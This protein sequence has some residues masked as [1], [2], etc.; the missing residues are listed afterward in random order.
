M[1]IMFCDLVGSTA[2]SARLDPEDLRAVIAAYYREVAAVVRRFG[3]LVARHNGDGALIYF[4]YPA[5]HEDD[6]QRAVRAGLALIVAIRGLK[7]CSDIALD[8]RIGIATGLVVIEMAGE[9]DGRRWTA[10]GETPNLAARL[11]TLAEPGT[12]VIASSTY[13]LT[14]ILFECRSL[15]LQDIKGF[16]LPV[17]V[18]QVLRLGDV[19]SRLMAQQGAR[20]PVVGRIEEIEQLMR[21]WEQAKAGEGRVV[22]ISG[23]A[24]IGKSR[25]ARALEERIGNEPHHRLYYF[26][27]ALYQDSAFFPIIGQLEH[28]AGIRREDSGETRLDKLEALLQPH[29]TD[30]R[31]EVALFAELLAIDGGDRYPPLRLSP[32]I[33]M[34]R[35]LTAL[36]SQLASL[37]A[38][39]PMLMIFEDAHWIDPSSH[40]AFAQAIEQLPT[41]PVLLILTARPEFQP[42]WVGLPHVTLQPL[43]RLNRRERIL[44]I[45]QLTNGKPLPAE[46]ME[47]IVE[48]ADGVP[49]FVEELT[50]TVVESGLLREG[51]D[52][53]VLYGP[54]PP[55]AIPTT[56]QASL[57]A[58][59]DRLGAP[60]EI[61]QEAAAIGR[62]FPYELLAA[63][64]GRNET[65][66]AMGLDQLVASGLMQQ[67]G[68]IPAASFS[69]K[70]ALMQ[71]AAYSTLVRTRRQALHGRI[72]EQ[73]EQHFSD[74][75]ETR[76]ELLAHHLAQAGFA[77]RSIGFWLK[78]ARVAIGRGATAE[79]VAQLH[80]GLALLDEVADYDNRRRQELELQIALGNA[81][82]A[83]TGY[84]GTETD[85]AFR[86]ARELCLEMGDTVQLT[87]VT[88]GQFTGHFAGGRQR[89]ALDVANE[90]LALSERFNDPGGRQIGNA[91]VG[92][93]LLHLAS[94]TAA[95]TKFE[96]ALAADSTLEREWTYLYGQSGR[97]AALAYMSLAQL[98]LG[99]PDAARRLTERSVEEARRLA[100]PTSQCFAHS[101]AS[102]VHYLLRDSKALAYHSSRVMQFAELHGLGLWQALG[103]IYVG[104]SRAET[105]PVEGAALI[106]D[107]LARY[108]VTGAAL[109][110]PLYLSSL[111]S[112]EAAGGHYLVALHLLD[113]ARA[114]SANGDEQWVS[115]EI[116]RLTGEAML[117]RNGDTAGAE[118]EF[119]AALVL[120]RE[121]GAKLWELRAAKSLTRL[122][123]RDDEAR[124]AHNDLAMVYNSYSEGFT[125][126][127]LE[128]AK[129]TLDA[130]G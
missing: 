9:G 115:A 15:G 48:R 75:I 107:G 114:A 121:Q 36:T 19:E 104:W 78:A 88:W 32:R 30:P 84:S 79:T 54:L 128:E 2:L 58:R 130:R 65:E 52:R 26:G 33:R 105:D 53:Y 92:S 31:Q 60:R 34:E 119:R 22:L 124:A 11:Q 85:A 14:G 38:Q 71:D 83:A 108:R 49:L 51:A 76:P 73:Y 21:R 127:D 61:A 57:L 59:L 44:M 3:G 6:A 28:A 69:F 77:E 47:Q 72:A 102:R 116:H 91:S 25:L 40:E 123:L 101:I 87:R 46:V 74:I 50:Q 62:D 42:D 110:L 86:R 20:A 12:V 90:L 17:T 96:L 106:R 27:S 94:F 64:S 23:E 113:E 122:T 39:R 43:N 7:P 81:L 8:A 66:L 93:S 29:S 45:E 100:H 55:L 35:T 129:A 97:V 10:L 98:L 99:F 68:V 1:T 117:V 63:V 89:L 118:R 24:G 82:A 41:L 4:G 5:A 126:L 56:L 37:S 103:R 13:R 67:R 80:R 109:C 70:H 18:W 95:C 111:A 120:A 112:V 125:E 16:D